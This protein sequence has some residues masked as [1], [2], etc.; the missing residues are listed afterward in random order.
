MTKQHK[1]ALKVTISGSYLTGKK[2]HVDFESLVGYIPFCEEEQ[3]T[4]MTRKRYAVMW[5]TLSKDY[6]EK[7]METR[8]CFIDKMEE[9]DHEFSF[10]NKS[11]MTLDYEELQDLATAKD[12]RAVPLYKVSGLRHGRT[13]AYV[14]FANKVL[15][16]DVDY[17]AEGFNIMEQPDIFIDAESERNIQK[18][19]TNDEMISMEQDNVTNAPTKKVLS[20]P[21]LEALAAKKNI[22]FNPAIKDG[23]LQ[24]KIFNA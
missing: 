2:E 8:E 22:T 12:L 13:L 19:I 14:E 6:P 10:I 4:A 9:V 24:E 16:W 23:K 1:N 5:L 18:T 15:G 20:R 17:R 3:A 21:Q 11:I 7:V